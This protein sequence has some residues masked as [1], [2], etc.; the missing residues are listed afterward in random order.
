MLLLL[1]HQAARHGE[2]LRKFPLVL[3][4]IVL[5]FFLLWIV[6]GFFFVFFCEHTN[7]GVTQMSVVV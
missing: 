1:L 2:I 4:C 3:S 5:S 6:L 7:I